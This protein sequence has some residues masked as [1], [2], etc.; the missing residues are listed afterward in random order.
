MADNA[1]QYGQNFI[2]LILDY[3][4][5]KIPNLLAIIYLVYLQIQYT[6]EI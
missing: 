3:V 6:L 4:N 1:H 2:M 5:T